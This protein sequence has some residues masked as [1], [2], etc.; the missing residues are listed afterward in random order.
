MNERF[1][2]GRVAVITGGNRGIGRATALALA[3]AGAKVAIA[4]RNQEKLA[5]TLALLHEAGADAAS[6]TCDVRDE[7][8]VRQLADDVMARFG[9]VHILV[10]NAGTAIRKNV[11]DFTMEEWRAL[12]D[13][14]ITGVWLCCKYFVPHMKGRGYGRILNLTSIMAH[15]SS[16][17]RGVYSATKHAVA[18][19]TKALALELVSDRITCVAI[20]PG[21][22]ATDLTAPLRADA[23]RNQALLDQT[24]MGRWGEADEIASLA[25]YLCSDKAA[26]MTGNDVLMDGGWCAQ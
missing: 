20:S 11:I 13:T 12:T 16:T 18:G 8:Q 17:G 23:A 24:P 22:V 9:A 19:L 1:L 5:E 25:L 14:N 26:F 7:A 6:F 21:F 15:V 10:N 3:G 4:G 2:S